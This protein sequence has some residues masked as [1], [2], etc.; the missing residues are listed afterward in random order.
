MTESRVVMLVKAGTS[1]SSTIDTSCRCAAGADASREPSASAKA[2]YVFRG[3]MWSLSIGDNIV[4]ALLSPV[5]GM[6]A[7]A[8]RH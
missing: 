3:V 5:A 2:W 1:T 4:T 8:C 6:A 7:A